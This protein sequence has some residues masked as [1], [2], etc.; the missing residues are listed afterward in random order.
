MLLNQGSADRVISDLEMRSLLRPVFEQMDE[1][2]SILIVPP[3]ATR[4]H[5]Y[6]GGITSLA[7]E[8]F[9]DRITAILPALGTHRPMTRTEIEYMF[10]R[11]PSTLFRRHYWR[12]DTV[13]IG[14]VPSEIVARFSDGCVTDPWP[15]QVNR[16]LLEGGFDLILSVGQVV[17]HEVTGMANYT[18]NILIGLGGADSINQS[19]FLSAVYGMERI[20]GRVDNPVR[21]VLDW[22]AKRYLTHLPIV[23]IQT[24]ISPDSHGKPVLRGL[25]A[26]R[27]RCCFEKAASL[28][29]CVNITRLRNPLEK[30]VVYLDPAEYHSLWLGNKSIYRTRMALADRGNLTVLAPG[31]TQFGED[32]EIDFLIR[33]YGYQG[34]SATLAA[35]EA[36]ADLRNNVCA[37][38]HLIH[39]SSEGRFTVTYC[40][41]GLSRDEICQSG[42]DYAEVGD[43]LRRYDPK[44]L[45]VGWNTMDDGELIYFI[46]NPALGLWLFEPLG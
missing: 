28:S 40:P 16:L 6:A 30:V 2:R 7:Y 12:S 27:D 14:H 24:V 22:G 15:V 25:F 42:Y 19:H 17:P 21:R 43:M 18:K 33:K 26:G 35:I 31:V 23:Y 11:V 44:R 37:A 9:G 4:P 32:A 38:A 10:P 46:N 20:M 1:A 13:T 41:G 45:S 34:T 3:D 8:Y 36:N 39:G 29:S 5:S